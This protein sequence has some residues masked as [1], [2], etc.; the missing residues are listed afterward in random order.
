MFRILW[1]WQGHLKYVSDIWKQGLWFKPLLQEVKNWLQNSGR[2]LINGPCGTPASGRDVLFTKDS[3]WKNPQTY[4]LS[5]RTW[6]F[7]LLTRLSLLWRFWKGNRENWQELNICLRWEVLGKAAREENHSFQSNRQ[8]GATLAPWCRRYA[9]WT[10][11]GNGP[12]LVLR[13]VQD[14][15]P[16]Q[17]KGVLFCTELMFKPT[18]IGF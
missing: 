11:P 8:V 7:L 9:A 2:V 10:Q 15:R 4:F 18:I 1:A 5:I 17:T 6:T 13:C 12:V 16:S 3:G 14:H